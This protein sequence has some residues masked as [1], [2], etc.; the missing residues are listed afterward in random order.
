M[1]FVGL[2]PDVAKETTKLFRLL[3]LALLKAPPPHEIPKWKPSLK[4]T[5]RPWKSTRW[6]F[7]PIWKILVKLDHSHQVGV[8][9]KNLWNHHLDLNGLEHEIS[10][11]WGGWPLLSGKVCKSDALHASTWLNLIQKRLEKKGFNPELLQPC[12]EDSP[13]KTMKIQ[14]AKHQHKNTFL[15]YTF[16]NSM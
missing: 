15:P 11:F 12:L 10:F 7:Q 9:I 6:W 2:A 13:S 3:F 4:L 5:V 16:Y 1:S 14:R 8:K